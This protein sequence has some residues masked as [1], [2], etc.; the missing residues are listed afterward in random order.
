MM[1]IAQLLAEDTAIKEKILGNKDKVFFPNFGSGDNILKEGIS[2]DR[3]AF[4]I[5]GTDFDIYWYGFLIC[6]GLLLAMVYGFKRMKS[7][8]IDPD[9]A[10]D[11]VIA[12]FL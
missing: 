11:S 12:V 8:G 10:T 7:V 4:T 6:I 5:P 1:Q 2:I 9:R 3:V